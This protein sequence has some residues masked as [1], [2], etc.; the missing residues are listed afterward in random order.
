MRRAHERV[1]PL[2]IES[3]VVSMTRG[4]SDLLA[5]LLMAK[6]AGVS[7]RLDIV[8]LFETVA[9][10]HRAPETLERLFANPAYARHLA[11]RGGAQTVMVGYS[12]SNKD[13]GYLTAN[14]ELHLA[15]R[16]LAAVCARHGVRLTLFHGRGGTVGRGGGP[17]N[18]AILAQPPESVG[19]RLRLTEQGESVTNRYADPALARRHLEQL[20]HAVLIAGGKRPMRTPSRGGAWEQAMNELAP[21]AERAYRGLVHERPELVRYLYAAT[22]IGEID[23]LNIGSRPARRSAAHDLAEPAR[24]PVGVRVDAEPRRAARLV[25]ARQR[26]RRLGAATTPRAGRCSARCTASGPSSRRWSTTRSSR[27]AAP[28]C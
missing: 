12:D 24:D 28:T 26:A 13:G 16:A 6:D 10:L 25:R 20:V 22:P 5:V 14:W 8:P 18:R 7:D 15:Q 1:G 27:C 17:T 9:D 19:G 11:A 23:R 3:Y 21:L 2:A 4:P